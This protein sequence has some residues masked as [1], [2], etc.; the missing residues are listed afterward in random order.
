MS[1]FRSL[2]ISLVLRPAA[3]NRSFGLLPAPTTSE[4]QRAGA[5][6]PLEPPSG[7]AERTLELDALPG[8]VVFVGR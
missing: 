8:R 3:E 2:A 1:K 6:R 5:A 7:I 4:S